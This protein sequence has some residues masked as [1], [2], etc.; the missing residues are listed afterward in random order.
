MVLV[1]VTQA[2]RVEREEGGWWQVGYDHIV[3]GEL[4]MY[5]YVL[6]SQCAVH[7]PWKH[8]WPIM[9][10]L[11]PLLRWVQLNVSHAALSGIVYSSA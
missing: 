6:P 4:Y 11:S 7:S 2:C 3:Y 5:M 10:L 1:S 9:P 8:H